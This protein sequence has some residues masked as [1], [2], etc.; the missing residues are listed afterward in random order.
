MGQSGVLLDLLVLVAVYAAWLLPK[1]RRLGKR[2]LLVY[3]LM[4]GCLAGIVRFT[5]TPVLTALPYCFDH[6]YIPMHMAPFEDV[7]HRHGELC[8]ADRAQCRPV[9][10]VW[11]CACRCA[12]APRQAAAVSGA[13]CCW[14][15][16][17]RRRRACAAAAAR[18][19][20]SGYY[21]RHHEHDRRRARLCTLGAWKRLLQ[22]TAGIGAELPAAF[23]VEN[24]QKFLYTDV[25]TKTRKRG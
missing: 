3:T 17:Q 7:I 19:P 6:P 13:A 12:I 15:G 23:P 5:L 21:G 1:W 10:S 16:A 18:F 8:A 24:R 14:H 9:S 20:Q 22:K 11:S 4:Y 25:V 2:L